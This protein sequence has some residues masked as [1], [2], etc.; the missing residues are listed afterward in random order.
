MRKRKLREALTLLITDKQRHEIEK[1]SNESGESLGHIARE[2]LEDGLRAR[3]LQAWKWLLPG[4]TSTRRH[5]QTTLTLIQKVTMHYDV[6]EYK[7]ILEA[8]RC[9]RDFEEL[10][11]VLLGVRCEDGQCI[12]NFPNGEFVLPLDLRDEL[13]ELVGRDIAIL[14]LGGQYH[15][16]EV[17]AGA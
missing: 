12:A 6:I 16:R 9:L 1:L 10:R 13:R 8:P 5:R 2:L 3:G 11:Y 14:R 7:S 15:I 17:V 4:V